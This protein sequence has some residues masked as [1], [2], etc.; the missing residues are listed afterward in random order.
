MNKMYLE[1]FLKGVKDDSYGEGKDR[2][3]RFTAQVFVPGMG[4]FNIPLI[5]TEQAVK[6]SQLPPMVTQFRVPFVL[7]SRAEVRTSD[8]TNAKYARDI[9]LVKFDSA[10]FEVTG[11]LLDPKKA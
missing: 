3:E 9:I 11:S 4:D 7:E 5:S 2:K 6:L 10:L 1:G 8:R